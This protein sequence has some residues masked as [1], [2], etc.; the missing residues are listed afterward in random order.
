MKYI[1]QLLI[2][3]TILFSK[4]FSI[5]IEKPFNDVLFDVTE[6]YDRKISAVGF[7]RNYD[8]KSNNSKTY[9][10]A[11]SYLKSVSSNHGSLMYLTKIDKFGKTSLN[12]IINISQ[13]GEA[14]SVVKTPSNGYFIG[15]DTNDGSILIIKLDSEAQT[16]FTRT[17]GTK[18]YDRLND[19]I[20]L[21]D[22]GVLTIGSSITS[23]Y[24]YDNIFETGLG[25][26]DIYVTRFSKNGQKLWSRKYG[27]QYDD[28][29]I[30]GVEASDGSIIIVST[31]TNENNKD[32]TLTRL[33]ENGDKLWL[34]HYKDINKVTPY[35][36]IKLKDNNFLLSFTQK[37]DTN[38][39][40]IRLIKFDL[41]K[42]ILI[43]KEIFTNYSSGLK[44]IKEFSNGNII[45][46]GFI[47]DTQNTDALVMIL[48]NSLNLV[49]QAHYGGKNFD[50]FNGVTITH[51]SKAVAVGINTSED[52]QES[53]MWIVKL[54]SD[55]SIS[56][57]PKQ[58]SDINLEIQNS[59]KKE[60]Q[61][62]KLFIKDDLDLEFIDKSLYFNVGDY[63]LTKKQKE[64]LDSFSKKLI[65]I[66]IKY[67]NKIDTLEINGHTS[68]EWG[69]LDFQNSYLKN[70]KLSMNRS[71]STLSYIFRNQDSKTQKILSK[72]IRGSGFSY[73]KNIKNGEDENLDKSRRVSFKIIMK[74]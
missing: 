16:I 32:L 12:K 71:Y 15:G 2:L 22:G 23:R 7:T 55:A 27:T 44:D 37:D 41:Y 52:S 30:S 74:Q 33:T 14:I 18:N 1:L 5:I 68:S 38:K 42:N 50:E 59:F 20:S 65:P 10:D 73:S 53:N 26:N 60:I 40:Q 28:Q 54:N 48:N 70:S 8:N 56:Q 25:L 62:N 58:K 4:D 36:V 24:S 3:T 19:L 17:I 6:D 64:F 13:F 69:N 47:N 57:L 9:T 61:N 39:E 49:K 63:K 31:T 67:N 45:G 51:N 43:D 72:I 46:T 21:R 29:G 11:F 34:K 66:L 35:K